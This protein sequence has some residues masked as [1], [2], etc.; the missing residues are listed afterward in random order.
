MTAVNGD[1][2]LKCAI[3]RDLGYG[4]G[5]ASIELLPWGEVQNEDMI[6][7]L[8]QLN[9]MQRSDDNEYGVAKAKRAHF[10]DVTLANESA[11]LVVNATSLCL[12]DDDELEL[13]TVR[14]MTPVHDAQLVL[15]TTSSEFSTIRL[16]FGS[17]HDR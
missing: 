11:E 13:G 12:N 16:C 9:S 4:R 15:E 17:G 14:R 3:G 1:D 10:F 5:M 7:F 2:L 6:D 8:R